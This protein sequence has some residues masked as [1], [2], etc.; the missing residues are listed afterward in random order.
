ME[1]INMAWIAELYQLSK[2]RVTAMD[3]ALQKAKNGDRQ[4]QA[5]DDGFVW[6]NHMGT[7]KRYSASGIAALKEVCKMYDEGRFYKTDWEQ[8]I[9]DAAWRE[10]ALALY[11]GDVKKVF[12]GITFV[13]VRD[14]I[15]NK[16]DEV[17]RRRSAE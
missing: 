1:I 2:A 5:T 7:Q 15:F 13:D 12:A 8:A 11:Y 3:A 14:Y 6:I 16:M 10:L 17:S 9:P 4:I